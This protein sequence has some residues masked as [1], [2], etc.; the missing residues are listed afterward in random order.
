MVFH[1]PKHLHGYKERRSGG[2]E[3]LRPP[4]FEPASFGSSAEH[5]NNCTAVP[6]SSTPVFA[7]V[8]SVVI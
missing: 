7:Y 8:R 3:K 1:M 2:L 5:R 4:G 6:A